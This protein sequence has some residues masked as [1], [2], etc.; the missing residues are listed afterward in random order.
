MIILPFLPLSNLTVPI[1]FCVVCHNICYSYSQSV[2]TFCTTQQF[3]CTNSCCAVCHNICYSYSQSVATFC[4]T[5]Q[6]NCANSCCAVCH[7]IC[8]SYSQS[9][10]TISQLI[11][12]SIQRIISILYS[13][14]FIAFVPPFLHTV[15]DQTAN[16][17][18]NRNGS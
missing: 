4:T 10:A 8:Y 14:L 6:F 3:N 11:A 1:P 9:V 16:V 7:N 2:A 13:K 12:L 17:A 5:Q 15:S 18:L